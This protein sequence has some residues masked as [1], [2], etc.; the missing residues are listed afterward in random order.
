MDLNLDGNN[1]DYN[2]GFGYILTLYM[3]D[4]PLMY[5]CLESEGIRETC[6]NPNSIIIPYIDFNIK[7]G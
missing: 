2:K 6:N 7:A 3:F 5:T 1:V 4:W